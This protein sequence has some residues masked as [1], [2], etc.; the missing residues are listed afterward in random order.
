[1]KGPNPRLRKNPQ[2][3]GRRFTGPNPEREPPAVAEV[4]KGKVRQPTRQ[5]APNRRY[6][7]FHRPGWNRKRTGSGYATT[8]CPMRL[9]VLRNKCKSS[10]ST[11]AMTSTGEMA[12]D[13]VA[14]RR[15]LSPKAS[16]GHHVRRAA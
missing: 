15:N 11:D 10:V 2:P 14:H 3:N 1:M 8:H 13:A 6:L 4:G 12:E 9:S 5:A 7:P 16:S